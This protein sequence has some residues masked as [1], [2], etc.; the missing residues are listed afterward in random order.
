MVESIRLAIVL[1]VITFM[2]GVVGWVFLANYGRLDLQDVVSLRTWRPNGES[3]EVTEPVVL[4]DSVSYGGRS[5]EYAGD[6]PV[7]QLPKKLQPIFAP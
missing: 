2:V 6:Y 3:A 1:A 4:G 5:V 7:V